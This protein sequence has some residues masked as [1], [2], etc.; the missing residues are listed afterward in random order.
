MELVAIT[1]YRFHVYD[2]ESGGMKPSKRWGTFDA[3]KRIKGDADLTSAVHVDA[4]LIRYDLPGL[5]ELGWAPSCA[6]P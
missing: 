3:I 4:A 6:T 5:T 1:L 2:P